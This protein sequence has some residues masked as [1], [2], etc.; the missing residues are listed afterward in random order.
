MFIL[1]FSRK[2]FFSLSNWKNEIPP[3]FLPWKKI[4]PIPM[5]V[6]ELLGVHS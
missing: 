4:L 6:E 1:I 2:K 3:L 5:A